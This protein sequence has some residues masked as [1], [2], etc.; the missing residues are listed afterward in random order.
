VK[1]GRGPDVVGVTLSNTSTNVTFRFVFAQAPP[2]AMSEARIVSEW[3]DML[4]VAIDTPPYG[5]KPIPGGE[6]RG[7]EYALGVHGPATTGT[8][9]QT[10]PGN[11]PKWRRLLDFEIATAGKAITFSIPRRTLGNPAS[12]RFMVVAAREGSEGSEDFAPNTGTFRYV[13]TG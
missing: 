1:G 5:A 12:F 6:W 7:A 10:G 9:T 3:N 8:M 2:L 11:P 4:L 13:L